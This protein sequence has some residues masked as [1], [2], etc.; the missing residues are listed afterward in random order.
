MQVEAIDAVAV[1]AILEGILPHHSSQP[2]VA[3]TVAGLEVEGVE[4]CRL[5]K[6]QNASLNQDQA[7]ELEWVS[8]NVAHV[9]VLRLESEILEEQ[10]ELRLVEVVQCQVESQDP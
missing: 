2:V 3:V 6:V 7:A 8:A 5:V 1:A 9:A 4:L 10:W